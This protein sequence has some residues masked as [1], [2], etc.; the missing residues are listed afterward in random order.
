[1]NAFLRRSA[2]WRMLLPFIFGI[3][4]QFYQRISFEFGHGLI[5]LSLLF[6]LACIL[7]FLKK[8]SL[9]WLFGLTLSCFSFCSG[10]VLTTCSLNDTQWEIP[11]ESHNY[12][13]LL[14]ED[15]VPKPK[16]WMCKAR[17]IGSDDAVFQKV[18]GKNVVLYLPL[19]GDT[20]YLKSGN[21]VLVRTI[22]K[23]PEPNKNSDFNY[24]D[25][26]VKQ[27]YAATGYVREDSWEQQEVS[28]GLFD[29]IKFA[30]IRS[31]NNIIRIIREFVP[32]E[33]NAAIAGGLFVGH[34]AD[35][36]QELKNAF[37]ET[38]TTH[39]LAVSGMHLAIIFS[40]L[41]LVFSP[42]ARFPHLNKVIRLFILLLLWFFAFVTGLSPSIVRACVM[43][44]FLIIGMVLNRKS[45]TMNA[46]A[47]SALFMLIYN[48]M[49]L[50]DVGF[51]LSYGAVISIIL[52]NPYLVRLKSFQSKISGYFWELSCV[53]TA[54]QVGTSPVS[55]FY[56]G[57]FPTIFLL[58]NMFAIPISGVLLILIPVCVLMHTVYDF[59]EAVYLPVNMLLDLFVSGIE[60]MNNIP[61]ST[62]KGI[63]FDIWLLINSYLCIY[64][65]FKR[66]DD[67]QP[68]YLYA[69]ILLVVLQV[70]LYL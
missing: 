1:M 45:F 41:C 26:L 25:Y 15:P 9:R 67:K 18:S 58:T 46:V 54:A 4:V 65:I 16:S 29:K 35:L 68:Q 17:V 2:F 11:P 70:F 3:T 49:Y 63:R 19:N 28:I 44:S 8:Y 50:F 23:K 24:A 59:P 20:E 30:G 22:L 69:I 13:V 6:I 47:A 32:D 66:I 34:R 62:I 40:A 31:R 39:I 5:L 51:Q 27:G 60:M 57:Q 38:G 14:L 53:S 36:S 61:F 21:G 55:M 33:E 10:V 42:F 56:F 64:L 12:T 7:F 52:I 43:T 37:A 48:P